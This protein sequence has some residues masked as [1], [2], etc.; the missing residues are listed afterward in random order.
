MT[1]PHPVYSSTGPRRGRWLD[2][3]CGGVLI[4]GLFTAIVGLVLLVNYTVV[5]PED[6]VASVTLAEAKDRLRANPTD[7]ALKQAVRELDLQ[8]R[9][10]YFRRLQINQ[11]GA[12]LLVIGAGLFVLATRQ[13]RAVA[14]K[15]HLPKRQTETA[16]YPTRAARLGRWAVAGAGGLLLVLMLLRAAVHQSSLPASLAD[17]EKQRAGEAGTMKPHVA[18]FLDGYRRNWP[19]F[20]GPLGTGIALVTNAPLTWDGATGAG[21]VWKTPVPAPGFSS[22]IV[23]DQHVFLAGGDAKSREV[24]CFDANTGDLLWRRPVPPPATGARDLPEAPE[25]TG[26]AACT[27]ATDGTR[28]FA[29][30]GSG[31]L[32]ALD[33]RGQ[34]VWSRNFGPVGNM[35]GHSTS[36]LVWR[37]R[38][39]VLLDQ[40]EA[41]ANKSRLYALDTATG[42]ELWQQSRPV[43]ASW[44]TP[45]AMEHA[46]Q[47]QLITLGDPWLIAYNIESGAELW[48]A[49]CLGADV[50]PSPVFSG[51]LVLAVSP[52]RHLAAVRPD[53]QGD[54]TETRIVWESPDGATD[55]TSPVVAGSLVFAV[56]T[57][58][59]LSCLDLATGELLAE[60]D[61]AEQ[62][63]A[64]PT[65]VGD[66]LYF[67]GLKGR[68]FVLTAT[69]ELQEVAQGALGEPVFASPAFVGERLF[70]R[71]KQHL[72]CLGEKQGATHAD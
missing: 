69:S 59:M 51:D 15:P 42:R 62:M 57:D 32:V 22:P 53:G 39:I 52:N 6:P 71:G 4:A 16:T 58:G 60:K 33:Y 21:V 47:T 70:V 66:R 18:L 46:G 19:M 72:F 63:N 30:F 61:F 17:W 2:F 5:S 26:Y 7:A 65:L 41:E 1:T 29:S 55:I 9:R 49:D 25:F 45:I 11:G 28:V 12:W 35:Y 36:L 31:E 68:S 14:E 38:L 13:V 27:P 3:A 24:M 8:A 54:V 56:S 34:V 20:R 50:A 43:G 40:D 10:T 64:S 48:R 37:D 44:A 23:W 67:F